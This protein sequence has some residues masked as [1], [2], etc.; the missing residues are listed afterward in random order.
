MTGNAAYDF[1][2]GANQPQQQ[3]RYPRQ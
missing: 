3:Q 2:T 1:G